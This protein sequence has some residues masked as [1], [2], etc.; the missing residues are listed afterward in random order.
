MFNMRGDKSE[1]C[2][3]GVGNFILMHNTNRIC[4]IFVAIKLFPEIKDLNMHNL[5]LGPPVAYGS[6]T[7]DLTD[8]MKK[9]NVDLR[10]KVIKVMAIMTSVNQLLLTMLTHKGEPA[11]TACHIH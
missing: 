1:E 11:L 4:H 6:T 3:G 9:Q 7:Y 2:I 10:G 5:N 8:M